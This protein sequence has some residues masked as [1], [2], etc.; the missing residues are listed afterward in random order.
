MQFDL[1]LTSVLTGKVEI[2]AYE[3]HDLQLEK[4]LQWSSIAVEMITKKLS[5]FQ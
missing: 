3:E 5:K 4:K 1:K 2:N